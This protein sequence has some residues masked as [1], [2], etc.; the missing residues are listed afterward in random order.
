M[1]D[2]DVVLRR[3]FGYEAFRPG[4]KEL[5]RAVLGGRDALGVLP[6]GGG[7]SICYQ[8]PSLMLDG[9]TVV[10]TPLVS[11]M[12][13]QVQRARAVGIA[14]A[15]LTAAQTA[16]ERRV[17]LGDVRAGRTRMLFVAPERLELPGFREAIAS[18]RVAL[19]AVDEAHCISQWGRDFRPAYRRIAAFRPTMAVPVLALT[20]SATPEVRRDIG[21]SLRLQSPVEVV[22]SFDRPNLRWAIRSIRSGETR[23]AP[24][25]RM[26]RR[27]GGSGIVYAPTR[28]TVEAVRR[29]L[30][31]LGVRADAYHA[32][33]PGAERS[34]I[35]TRFMAGATR[36]VVATNAFGM[37]IDK[38][39]VR[40]VV[41]THLPSTLEAYYQEAGRAGRDGESADC[42]AFHARPDRRLGGR[43]IGLTHPPEWSLRLLYHRLRVLARPGRRV[44]VTD[45]RVDASLSGD[46]MEWGRGEPTGPLAALERIGAI[47]RVGTVVDSSGSST[48]Y[49]GILSRP[50]WALASR[51]RRSALD[52]LDAV[53]RLARAKGCRRNR[54]LRYFGEIVVD[55]CGRCDRCGWDSGLE[56]SP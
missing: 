47:R 16:S 3:T 14:A 12:E 53:Q 5:V 34:L 46:P 22:R 50:D 30:A 23:T 9:L 6:T 1:H 42:V 19:V 28:A 20:A 43:L 4:Q 33:L 56:T 52:R 29:S 32:G 48:E 39:D 18:R 26:V 35:Q 27:S 21:V 40:F 10:V 49:I 17:V 44:L 38:P 31:A 51:L 45:P 8:V 54:L 36:V 15:C 55:P 7:K 24:L 11:L 37:G 25:S 41:H 13:D 2:P